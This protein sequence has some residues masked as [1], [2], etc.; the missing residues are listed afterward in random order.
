LALN[1]EEIDAMVE[2]MFA[3]TDAR[4]D[5]QNQ[6]ALKAQRKLADTERR[7]RDT[8][9]AEREVYPFEER[10]MGRVR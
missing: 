8:A 4:F 5:E 2:F 1:E 9:M 6:R 10:V 7:F 3:L